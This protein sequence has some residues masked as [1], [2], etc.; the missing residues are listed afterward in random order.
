MDREDVVFV[1]GSL[2]TASGAWLFAPGAGL[3]VGGLL[4]IAWLYASRTTRMR[5]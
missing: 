1:G 5:K 4:L 3:I 2:L